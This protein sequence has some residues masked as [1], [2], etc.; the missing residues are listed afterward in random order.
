MSINI[1]IE[2]VHDTK[3]TVVDVSTGV[4][5]RQGFSHLWKQNFQNNAFVLELNKSDLRVT[6]RVSEF[7]GVLET[8]WYSGY[9]NKVDNVQKLIDIAFAHRYVQSKRLGVIRDETVPARLMELIQSVDKEYKPTLNN[10]EVI[11]HAHFAINGLSGCKTMSNSKKEAA[12]F[13]SYVDGKNAVE[14]LFPV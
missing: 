14:V 8:T 2:Q 12:F 9:L 6:R 5:L 10:S 1:S 3:R 7:R 4:S 13:L 11:M